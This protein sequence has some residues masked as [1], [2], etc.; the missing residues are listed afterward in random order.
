M[1]RNRRVG[2]DLERRHLAKLSE[3]EIVHRRFDL[4]PSILDEWPVPRPT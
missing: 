1:S 3:P 4:L 2:A